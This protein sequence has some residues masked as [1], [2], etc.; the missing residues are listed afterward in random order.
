MRV[1]ISYRYDYTSSFLSELSSSVFS[2]LST[3]VGVTD[4]P[5]SMMAVVSSIAASL[6]G[7]FG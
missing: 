1:S 5:C 4:A 3:L 6:A 2:V 7:L